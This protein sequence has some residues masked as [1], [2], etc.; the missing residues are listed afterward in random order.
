MDGAGGSSGKRIAQ[1]GRG[2]SASS[3]DYTQDTPPARLV[4]ARRG[5]GETVVVLRRAEGGCLCSWSSFG[6]REVCGLDYDGLVEWA[7][8]LSYR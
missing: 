5:L 8:N 7:L 2:T 6:P 4:T 1:S 3:S